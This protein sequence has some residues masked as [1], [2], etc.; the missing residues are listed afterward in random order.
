MPA[1]PAETAPPAPA[2]PSA[3]GTPPGI[4]PAMPESLGRRRIAGFPGCWPCCGVEPMIGP[5][6]MNVLA[7]FFSWLGL[8]WID[9]DQ[10]P[11]LF[12][13]HRVGV[14]PPQIAPVVEVFQLIQSGRVAVVLAH[15]H[16]NRALVLLPAVDQ[17]LLLGSLRF[18]SHARQFHVQRDS[19]AGGHQEHQQQR[20]ARFSPPGPPVHPTASSCKGRVCWVFDSVSSMT[21]ELMPMRT[22]R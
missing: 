20:V 16:L 2:V 21:T 13:R 17:Q 8:F 19:D 5:S 22:T 7:S 14:A 9:F 1:T 6:P 4:C 11:F 12:P 3:P 10:A 15:E 18:E